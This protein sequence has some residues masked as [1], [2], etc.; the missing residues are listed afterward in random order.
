MADIKWKRHGNDYRSSDGRWTILRL[1]A[2]DNVYSDRDEWTLV[3]LVED[4]PVDVYRLL[5]DAKERAARWHT[6]MPS[7]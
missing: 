4:E 5:R 6:V 3:D 7:N 2:A 1:R